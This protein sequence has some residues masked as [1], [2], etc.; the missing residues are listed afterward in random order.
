MPE[1]LHGSLTY[2]NALFQSLTSRPPPFHL[3]YYKGVGGKMQAKTALTVPDAKK[4]ISPNKEEKGELKKD[5]L[6]LQLDINTCG[7]I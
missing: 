1:A 5:S 6:H 7:E 2:A 3:K 4:Q